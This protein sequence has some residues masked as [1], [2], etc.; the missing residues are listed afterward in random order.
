MDNITK[1][2]LNPN[3]KKRVK[4]KLDKMIYQQELKMPNG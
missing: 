3:I 4:K 2:R 1:S